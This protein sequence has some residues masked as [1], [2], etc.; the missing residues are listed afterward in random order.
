MNRILIIHKAYGQDDLQINI[1]EL[2]S[3]RNHEVTRQE[4]IGI[5]EAL[6]KHLPATTLN[7]TLAHLQKLDRDLKAKESTE[8]PS[9]YSD[10]KT[11]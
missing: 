10:M 1:T 11:D 7:A 4:G 5:A 9:I 8:Y 3:H 6:W 2:S